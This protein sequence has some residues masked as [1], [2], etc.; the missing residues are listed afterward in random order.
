M[1]NCLRLIG[2]SAACLLAANPPSL[3]Q[4]T[5]SPTTQPAGL[6]GTELQ[7]SVVGVQARRASRGEYRSGLMNSVVDNVR[8][9]EGGLRILVE[10]H[11]PAGKIVA[12]DH[13]TVQFNVFID[14]K[15]ND[16]R[17]S[18]NA[19]NVYYG[20]NEYFIADDGRSGLLQ[21]ITDRSPALEA[22]RF[23][24]RGTVTITTA[25]DDKQTEPVDVPLELGRTLTIGDIEAMVSAVSF[26]DVNRQ[27]DMGRIQ[28]T[29]RSDQPLEG[30]R[31]ARLTSDAA[32]TTSVSITHRNNPNN[33]REN[34]V[35]TMSLYLP[36]PAEAR[37]DAFSL[38][39]DYS[40]G[41]QE[42]D[43]TFE[44]E[45]DLGR[46]TIKAD[47]A[48]PEPDDAAENI[49]VGR[50]EKID[51]DRLLASIPTA[52]DVEFTREPFDWSNLLDGTWNN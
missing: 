12:I 38:V 52:A 25:G 19:G 22:E 48:A 34:T 6:G 17:P 27:G 20:N 2:L 29:L 21:I 44:I 42:Q 5:T 47:P 37:A 24:A 33:P 16:L 4:P 39:F 32:P 28:I 35:H 30:I 49:E 10:F 3:A 15:G 36:R 41:L 8:S 11:N 9:S 51:W 50:R 18:Q 23:L 40:D 43:V 13:Q 26:T 46:A 14:D 1:S 7:A 45:A 31:S